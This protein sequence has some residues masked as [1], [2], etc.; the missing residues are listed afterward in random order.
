MSDRERVI[1]EVLA[2]VE[3]MRRVHG[4]VNPQFSYLQ[5]AVNE[6]MFDD[7]KLYDLHSKIRPDG[8]LYI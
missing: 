7:G 5:R 3:L 1:M 2:S 6:A 4:E 8:Q